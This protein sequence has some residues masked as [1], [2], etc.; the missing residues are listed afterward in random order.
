MKYFKRLLCILIPIIIGIIL[1]VALNGFLD[2]EISEFM[3][4]KDISLIKDKT[5]SIYKDKG[6]IFNDYVNKNNDLIVQGSSEL[7]AKIDQ[8]ITKTFPIEGFNKEITTYGRAHTQYLAQT[9]ILGSFDT[10]E[11]SKDVVLINSLQWFIEKPGI[12]QN[13]FQ[14]TF[15][16]V[17]FYEYL[18]NEK[19]SKKNK[20]KYTKRVAELL[21]GSNQ[22]SSEMA[23]AKLFYKENWISKCVKVILEPYYTVRKDLV[24]LKDKGL[25]YKELKTLPEKQEK[26]KKTINWQEEYDK[27]EEEGKKLVTN[28]EFSVLDTYYD[29]YLRP[30]LDELRGYQGGIDLLDTIEYEDY[31][32]YLDTCVDLGIKPYIVLMPTNGIW[33]DYAGISMEKRQAFYAKV[34]LM[35]KERG[36]EVLNLQDE[37]YNPHFMI[38]VMHLGWKGWL[39]V[40]EEIY[41]KYK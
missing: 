14:S 31:E 29:Q 28:N 19:I 30:N 37:E 13:D 18:G 40:D 24:G 15:S 1:L 7:G 8:V 22:F 3:T 16:P 21:Y 36:F 4:S 10:K 35:A 41:N 12:S 5:G 38:D 20:M 25:L 17:Q 23:Y 9:T 34:E 32:L 2:R 26:E 33:Y 6:V 39:R 27:A 11:G